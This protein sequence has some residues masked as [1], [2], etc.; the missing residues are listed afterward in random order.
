MTRKNASAGVLRVPLGLLPSS[1][2]RA[3]PRRA[4]GVLGLGR[5]VR[6]PEECGAL[7]RQRQERGRRRLTQMQRR[8]RRGAADGAR[9]VPP[10]PGVDALP[11]SRHTEQHV[12]V[13]EAPSF[14][15]FPC[16]LASPYT[17]SGY[18][19]SVASSMSGET[20]VPSTIH[21]EEDCRI[22]G[23]RLSGG[24]VQRLGARSG[25]P[26]K[27]TAEQGAAG[28]RGC[29]GEHPGS[30]PPARGERS[31]DWR[32]SGGG[33]RGQRARSGGGSRARQIRSVA[34]G[35]RRSVPPATQGVGAG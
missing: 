6:S 1:A 3:V 28:P 22:G 4:P 7:F 25:E 33:I 15:F 12:H 32:S 2:R 8:R 16:F 13:V 31:G 23:R 9:R 14:L 35:V 34:R 20:A 26:G 18:P 27:G 24:G 19:F 17:T 21:P 5:S 11:L 30:V 29:V 10:K